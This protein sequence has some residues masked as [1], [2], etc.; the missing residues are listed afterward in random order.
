MNNGLLISSIAALVLLAKKK[1]NDVQELAQNIEVSLSNIQGVSFQG[2]DV[3]IKLS[4]SLKNRTAHAFGFDIGTL[5]ELRKINVYRQNGDVLAEASTN[6]SGI[7]IDPYG[8]T[9]IE[10]I[11]VKG[12]V[13]EALHEYFQ[14]EFKGDYKIEAMVS[15]LGREWLIS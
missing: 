8:E 9:I 14:N 1:T 12:D 4:L 5:L 3:V 11:E 2:S 6:I 7:K 15:S 13:V 10:N